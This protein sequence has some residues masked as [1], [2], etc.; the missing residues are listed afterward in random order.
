MTQY[1]IISG[2]SLKDA[3]AFLNRID[4][5]A[6][7]LDDSDYLFSNQFKILESPA[8]FVVNFTGEITAIGKL[9]KQDISKNDITPNRQWMPHLD[10]SYDYFFTQE[11]DNSILTYNA[12]N[13]ELLLIDRIGKVR[14]S[15]KTKGVMNVVRNIFYKDK[16]IYVLYY[17]PITSG[18]IVKYDNALNLIESIDIECKDSLY[19]KNYDLAQDSYI[20]AQGKILSGVHCF[21]DSVDCKQKVFSITKENGK[22]ERVF[23]Y[24]EN[25]GEESVLVKD[26]EQIAFLSAYDPECLYIYPGFKIFLSEFIEKFKKDNGKKVLSAFFYNKKI[27]IIYAYDSGIFGSQSNRIYYNIAVLDKDLKIDNIYSLGNIYNQ[28]HF[29]FIDKLDN[30]L[31]KILGRDGYGM[32]LETFRL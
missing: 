23:E 19:N 26:Y 3:Q 4:I 1:L 6:I 20:D 11:I 22:I 30:S 28:Y 2:Q 9:G 15:I 7:P 5:S 32:F 29:I 16:Y 8:F 27:Y 24:Q 14:N 17:S 12:S 10:A 25:T 21:Y 31:F 13:N 18:K